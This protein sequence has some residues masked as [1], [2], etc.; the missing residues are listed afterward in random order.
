MD[1][2]FRVLISSFVLFGVGGFILAVVW[3][4][5]GYERRGVPLIR[6]PLLRNE[7]DSESVVSEADS[8]SIR[9]D[10]F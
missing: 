4:N 9:I 5:Y 2:T 8:E 6:E 7:I 3:C 1:D 10:L